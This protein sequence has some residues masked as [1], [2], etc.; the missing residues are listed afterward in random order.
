MSAK[1]KTDNIH[2][3]EWSVEWIDVDELAPYANNARIND[4]TVPYLANSIKRFGFLQPLVI[5]PANE[6]VCGHTRLKAALKVGLERLPCVRADDLTEDELNAFR[7]ADNK[8]AEMSKWDYSKLEA[9]LKRISLDG[10]VDM[11]DFGFASFDG[12]TD[13][14]GELPAELAGLD[15][16]PDELA[17]AG[18]DAEADCRVI[19]TFREHQRYALADAIRVKELDPDVVT[20]T[21]EK[22]LEL[23]K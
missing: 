9:E 18:E 10:E 14:G 8:I 5:G 20:Y 7:L 13:I 17:D 12:E 2:P 15:L 6:I 11:S 4:Y 3:N 16:E 1:R 22:L 19:L 23:A 21:V